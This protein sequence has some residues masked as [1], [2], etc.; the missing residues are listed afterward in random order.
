MKKKKISKK[1]I[2]VV[3]CLLL[4]GFCVLFCLSHFVYE[5]SVIASVVS[6]YLKISDRNAM[7]ADEE[8]CLAAIEERRVTNLQDIE[9]PEL[10]VSVRSSRE[11]GMQIFYLNEEKPT[12]SVIFYFHGGA[13]M[14]PPVNQQWSFI[15]DLSSKLE[16]PVVMPIYFKATNYTCDEA[17]DAML[18]FYSDYFKE[19]NV[20]NV[21][22]LGDSSGGGFA[23]SLA[24]QLKGTDLPEPCKIVLISP[25]TDLTMKNEEIEKYISKDVMLGLPGL[26]ILASMWAGERALDDSVVSPFY[27]ELEGLGEIT[28]FI[29]TRDMLYPDALLLAQRL[30]EAKADYTLHIGKSMGHVYPLLPIPEAAEAER[31]IIKSFSF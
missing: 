10:K 20:K 5:R 8:T 30:D 28:I 13:F 24:Q 17:Y 19:K 15:D 29:G 23:L 12:D 6:L 25:W 21:Y 26:K 16:I 22:F 11:R 14:N 31:I 3:L 9:D 2:V 4:A 7:F 18:S 1:S 27:G